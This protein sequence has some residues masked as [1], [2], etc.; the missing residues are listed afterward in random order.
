M[1]KWTSEND[2][3]QFFALD[4]PILRFLR[5]EIL[6]WVCRPP[7]L[8]VSTSF[9]G[10]V[11]LVFWVCRI[12]LLILHSSRIRRPGR[13]GPDDKPKNAII[14]RALRMMRQSAVHH[15]DYHP[16]SRPGGRPGGRAAGRAAGQTAVCFFVFLCVCFFVLFCLATHTQTPLRRT[17]IP[18]IIRTWPPKNDKLTRLSDVKSSG[19]SG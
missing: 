16:G 2:S 10:C 19:H 8:G 6:L 11:D 3:L 9:F 17:K 4:T 12:P 14:I 7:F 5:P 1:V 18:F 15:P 13:K